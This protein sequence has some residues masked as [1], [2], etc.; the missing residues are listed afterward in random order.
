[1]EKSRQ[2]LNLISEGYSLQDISSVLNISP[3]NLTKNIQI[4]RNKGYDF[5]EKYYETGDILYTLTKEPFLETNIG[6]P[7]YT[8]TDNLELTI[9]AISDLHLGNKL[10]N[11]HSLEIIYNYCINNNIHIIINTGDIID[12]LTFGVPELKKYDNYHEL[13]EKSLR[14]YPQDSQIINFA[15]LG[16]HDIDGLLHTGQNLAKYL[17][18]NRPDIIPIGIGVGELIIKNSHILIKHPLKTGNEP[19]HKDYQ[20]YSFILRGHR[21]QTSLIYSGIPQIFVPSLSNL[22]FHGNELPPEALQL[23]IRFNNGNINSLNITQLIVKGKVY[24]V[25]HLQLDLKEGKHRLCDEIKYEET[26][27]KRILKP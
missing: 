11:P 22:K 5:T 21:H 3:N 9:V 13:I 6:I 10:E 4:L 23:T 2:I 7:I 1:M 26:Y 12:A 24:P 15:T 25:N 18:Q 20:D 14:K 27:K 17:K 8:K 16:N 19:P